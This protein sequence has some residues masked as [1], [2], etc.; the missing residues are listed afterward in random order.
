MKKCSAKKKELTEQERKMK[1]NTW[2]SIKKMREFWIHK[3]SEDT[4]Q[5][6]ERGVGKRKNSCSQNTERFCIPVLDLTIISSGV[7]RH[8]VLLTNSSNL[9]W[10]GLPVLGQFLYNQ[11]DVKIWV[12]TQP[13]QFWQR[14]ILSIHFLILRVNYVSLCANYVLDIRD[15]KMRLS[16]T[17]KE[18]T[19]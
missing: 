15:T 7:F 14:W 16:S 1:T 19:N 9:R 4:N 6:S 13:G 8:L 2:F 10:R 12:V 11:N 3:S 5:L 18:L 17:F